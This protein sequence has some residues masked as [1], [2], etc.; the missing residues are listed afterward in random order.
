MYS[1]YALTVMRQKLFAPKNFN[2]LRN[3]QIYQKP[4]EYKGL[5]DVNR[6]AGVGCS[7]PGGEDNRNGDG[8][9]SGSGAAAAG[10]NKDVG[11][12]NVNDPIFSASATVHD[13]DDD[14]NDIIERKDVII[15]A[16]KRNE[17]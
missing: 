1:I 10:G 13:G 11:H 5:N 2:G 4:K 9:G 16:I 14:V 7:F 3:I 15:K 17:L 12:N 6:D 8:R